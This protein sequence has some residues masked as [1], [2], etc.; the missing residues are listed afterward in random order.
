MRISSLAFPCLTYVVSSQLP[1][2]STEDKFA[3]VR[4]FDT[5]W[6]SEA[7]FEDGTA[8]IRRPAKRNVSEETPEAESSWGEVAQGFIRRP[9][10]R[11]SEA[12]DTTDVGSISTDHVIRRPAK[13]DGQAA[14]NDIAGE[15]IVEAFIR[16][17]ARR[18]IDSAT[19]DS[20]EDETIE[21]FIRRPAR[22]EASELE[23]ITSTETSSVGQDHLIRRP[24]KRDAEPEVQDSEESAVVEDH[25][26]RRPAKRNTEP[27][28]QDS[29]E[30]AVVE[31]HL[32]RRPA[33]RTAEPAAQ[34]VPG[35]ASWG[36]YPRP[37][38][39]HQHP[40]AAA[41]A[42]AGPKLDRMIS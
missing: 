1:I 34:V 8:L 27:E 33:K 26:I 41:V 5:L 7:L 6:S 40:P 42:E 15:A 3:T 10:K 31:D 23:S 28:V 36:V 9:A 38:W 2:A 21:A 20:A 16:R 11:E 12:C 35:Y 30:S 24:A 22:R 13:R 14:T 18:D 37:K 25:L 32:I 29:E 17:P 4:D 39:Q 19:D